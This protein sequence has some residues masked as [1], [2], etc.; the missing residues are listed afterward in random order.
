M[1]GEIRRLFVGT[2]QDATDMMKAYYIAPSETAMG[3]FHRCSY[4]SAEDAIAYFNGE[5]DE[6]PDERGVYSATEAAEILGVSRMRVNQ[7][8][9]EGK[10]EGRKIGNAWQVYRYSV[11]NR[12]QE[13]R[14]PFERYELDA[15]LG[16]FADD[17][18]VDA[19]LDEAT[20]I[21]PRAGNRYWIDGIDLAEI[22]AKH[23]KEA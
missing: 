21:D 12:L 9:N 2:E 17:F 15:Y 16:D 13:N 6:L 14:K 1:T 19:I 8:L 23:E 10:L 20:E 18:D 5:V 11:E 22:C 7:L 3:S 4:I